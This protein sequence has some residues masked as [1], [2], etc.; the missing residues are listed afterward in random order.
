MR[1]ARQGDTPLHGETIQYGARTQQDLKPVHHL[2][3]QQQQQ[4]LSVPP[5]SFELQVGASQEE[6]GS[7]R[8]GLPRT[9]TVAF[10]AAQ[11]LQAQF[12]SL[13]QQLRQRRARISQEKSA[14]ISRSDEGE[15]LAQGGN[16]SAAATPKVIAAIDGESAAPSTEPAARSEAQQH[17]EQL[18][19]RTPKRPK[20][21]SARRAAL[22]PLL[23][24][25]RGNDE[26]E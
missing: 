24:I 21:S 22:G 5:A 12:A 8:L 16:S 17:D 4:Q 9:H 6:F 1:L 11:P 15:V 10:P 3:S 2:Q 26:L 18:S 20:H 25:L 13:F 14:G 19:W 23:S 7:S